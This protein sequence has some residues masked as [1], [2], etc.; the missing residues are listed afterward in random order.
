[1]W[2]WHAVHREREQLYVNAIRDRLRDDSAN[3][4]DE[5]LES[6]Q[7]DIDRWS[8]TGRRT[9]QAQGKSFRRWGT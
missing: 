2:Q 3:V 8:M 5:R 1:M 6:F 9:P 7:L 4:T